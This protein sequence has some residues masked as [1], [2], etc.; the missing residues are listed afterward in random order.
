MRKQITKPKR[1]QILIHLPEPIKTEIVKRA[2]EESRSVS[3][4]VLHIL[5]RDLERRANG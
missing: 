2:R 1:A 5:K 4:H 3:A